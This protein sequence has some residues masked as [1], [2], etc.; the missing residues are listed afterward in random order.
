LR[1]LRRVVSNWLLRVGTDLAVDRQDIWRRAR[2]HGTRPQSGDLTAL[3]AMDLWSRAA[4]RL[5]FLLMP[6]DALGDQP[7]PVSTT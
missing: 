4:L 1:P 5:G 7:N 3:G 2:E 6:A